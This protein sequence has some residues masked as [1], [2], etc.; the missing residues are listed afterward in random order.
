MPD[1]QRYPWN[2]YLIKNVKD[3]VV[4]LFQKVFISV[5]FSIALCKQEMRKSLS[6]KKPQMKIN[7]KKL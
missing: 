3:T 2:L 6:P 1:L 4:I 5:S 7:K